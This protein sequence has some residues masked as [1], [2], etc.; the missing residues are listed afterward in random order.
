MARTRRQLARRRILS[1]LVPVALVSLIALLPSVARSSGDNAQ[2]TIATTDSSQVDVSVSAALTDNT[3][4][5]QAGSLPT[6]VAISSA[7]ASCSSYVVSQSLQSKATVTASNISLLDG[8]VTVGSLTVTATATAGGGAA[9]V[10]IGNSAISELEI[11]G[12]APA[13]S[14]GSIPVPGVGTLTIFPMHSTTGSGSASAQLAGLQLQVTSD[15]AAVPQGTVIYVGSVSVRA[16]LATLDALTGTPTPSP[17]PTRTP[18]PTPTSTRTAHPSPAPTANPTV[19]PSSTWPTYSPMPAPATPPVDVLA[20]FPGAVFPVVGTY[21]YTDT[22][23]AARPDVAG[24]HQGADIFAAYGSP[25]VAVQNGVVTMST[26]G[27]GGNNLHLANSQGDY[28]YY[29]HLSRFATG[30]QQG[31]HVLAGQTLGYVGTTGDAQGTPPHLHFEIHPNGGPAVDPT[32]Y[33]DAWRSAGHVVTAGQ[34]TT[35]TDSTAQAQSAATA[36]ADV[37]QQMA[38]NFAAL[39]ASITSGASNVPRHGGGVDPVGAVFVVLNTAGAVLIK[40]L[41]LGA[42]L[43]L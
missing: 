27:I 7:T 18:T 17:T 5:I 40:R 31:E 37:L 2:A 4:T 28:F 14:Q 9:S 42:A 25:V 39:Q 43:L 19:Y 16:D 15:T 38:A 30:L 11:Q 6:G 29:A 24:G 21:T 22:F 36:G 10:N 8:A 3:S 35:Q 1:V 34:Q 20:R 13:S 33:L 32:P 41:Q 23:G 26:Y 12:V